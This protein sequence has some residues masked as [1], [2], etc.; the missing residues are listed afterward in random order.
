MAVR[1]ETSDLLAVDTLQ[2]V[3]AGD[4][5]A[6][7]EVLDLYSGLVWALARRFSTTQADAEDAVQEIFLDVWK[8]AGRYDAAVASEAT[9]IAMIARRRLI[10]RRRR[11]SR[12]IGTVE[13]TDASTPPAEGVDADAGGRSQV[14]EEAGIA[15]RALQALRPEQQQVL[16]LSVLQGLSHE[17]IAEATGLPLGTV[18]THIRRGLI[19]V[20][21]LIEHSRA[22]SG[23]AGGGAERGAVP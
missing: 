17:S 19:R 21:E 9:F 18:K 6:V 16:R 15:S 11:A 3:A 13:A 23:P 14:S 20:R 5:T 1:K 12:R 2:R 10:D 22:S 8:C 4:A 7:R